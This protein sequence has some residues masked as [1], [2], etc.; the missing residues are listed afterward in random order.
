MKDKKKGFT[1]IELLVVIAI[2]GILA[3]ILLP[4]LAR[5]REAARRASCANNLRQFGQIFAMY[6]NESQGEMYPP[7]QSHH[8]STAGSGYAGFD[9]LSLYPD[10]W[11]DVS[12]KVCPSDSRTAHSDIYGLE[13]DVAAQFQEMVEFQQ[14]QGVQDHPHAQ[15]VNNGFLSQPISYVYAGY[16]TRTTSQMMDLL[17]HLQWVFVYS[18]QVPTPRDFVTDHENY[19]APS[20][21]TRVVIQWHKGHVDIP[22][23]SYHQTQFSGGLDLGYYNLDDDGSE[24]P[25]MYARLRDGIERFFITDINNPA[26][27]AEAQSSIPTMY[28]AWSP[29]EQAAEHD[30]MSS[31]RASIAN[32]NHV[33]G[34]ANVL[35]MD[36]HVEFIRYGERSPIQSLRPE[37]GY[38]ERAVGNLAPYIM[39]FVVGG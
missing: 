38:P 10:Y 8:I 17:H 31:D 14:R 22:R 9:G 39:P 36:G 7:Q 24:M 26:A 15:W 37:D 28:D 32:F 1:L 29:G 2:I 18:D 35:F 3:A 16:A 34:G 30:V 20:E 23:H 6:A 33:P 5:A 27:G 13:D 21:W 11:T 25:D 4:A 19:G 12:L